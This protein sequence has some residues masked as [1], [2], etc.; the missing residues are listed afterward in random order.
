VNPNIISQP[1]SQT[2]SLGSNVAFS[3]TVAGLPPP[4]LQWCFNGAPIAGE[5]KTT[6]SIA[7]AQTSNAGIYTLTVNYTAGV[8]TSSQATLTVNTGGN[9]G[10]CSVSGSGGGGGGG[11]GAPSDWFL[12]ALAL[13]AL[14]RWISQQGQ[15][16]TVEIRHS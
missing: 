11:G 4:T 6:Y 9:G 5:T 3:I 15:G 13:M 7:S 14:V 16:Y 8:N 12:G 1:Q 10:G 2:V